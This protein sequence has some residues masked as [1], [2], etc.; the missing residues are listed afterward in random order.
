[1]TW[2]G[3][4]G[5]ILR[6]EWDTYVDVV[7]RGPDQWAC[8][9]GICNHIDLL[10]WYGNGEKLVFP[11]CISDGSEELGERLDFAGLRGIGD[12][13]IICAIASG[14]LVIVSDVSFVT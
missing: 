3:V 5:V 7:D 13:L 12:Y 4:S 11:N 14:I 1:M 9:E 6:G 2:I 8:F 10:A